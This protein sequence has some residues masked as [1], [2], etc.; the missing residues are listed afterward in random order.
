MKKTIL[1]FG[2]IAGA[3]VSILM[4]INMTLWENG[5]INLDN[6]EYLGY[7]G[8]VIAF[9][10]VFFGVKSYRDNYAEGIISFGKGVQVGL[11]IT[12]VASLM[13]VVSWEIYYQA[14]PGIQKLFMEQYTEHTLSKMHEKN[15]SAEEIDSALQELKDWSEMYKNPFFRYAIAL[16][17]ISP[18]GILITLLSATLFRRKEFLPA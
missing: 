9:S 8:M 16:L 3:L 5:I 11:L 4:I 15:A 6:G 1:V 7:T 17:E 18:V 12:L 14:K 13:Y 10:M 2:L